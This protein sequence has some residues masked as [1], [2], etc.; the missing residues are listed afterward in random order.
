MNY[1][2]TSML[3][4][5]VTV[6]TVMI[7]IVVVLCYLVSTNAFSYGEKVFATKNGSG[8]GEDVVV[9]IPVDASTREVASIL[10]ENG[11]ISD[12]NIFRLQAV[13]FELKINPGTYTFN[14]DDDVDEIIEEIS[15]GPEKKQ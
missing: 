6:T 14:T 1:K 11:L 15:A 13:L 3:I 5:R 8:Q 9:T 7:L 12:K 4:L 10:E 2:K